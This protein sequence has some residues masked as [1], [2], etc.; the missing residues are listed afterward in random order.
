M[1]CPSFPPQLSKGKSPAED[2]RCSTAPP[3][4][5]HRKI[6]KCPVPSIHVSSSQRVT[7]QPE[8]QSVA[9]SLKHFSKVVPD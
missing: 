6:S 5:S 8:G 1:C 7:A 9:V 2:R 3:G 4:N